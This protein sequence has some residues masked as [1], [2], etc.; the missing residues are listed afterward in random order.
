MDALSAVIELLAAVKYS[1]IG[2]RLPRVFL[3]KEQKYEEELPRCRLEDKQDCGITEQNSWFSS[4][5]W[6]LKQC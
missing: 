1:S 6:S 3:L 2:V 4:D 5:D